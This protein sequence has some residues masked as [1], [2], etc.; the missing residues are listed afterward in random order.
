MSEICGG[1][2]TPKYKEGYFIEAMPDIFPILENNLKYCNQ[3]HGTNYKPINA[4][5]TNEDDETY[6]F[7]IFR[8]GAETHSGSS[9]IYE[10][11]EDIWDH[12]IGAHVRKTMSI[13]L[14]STK[15][16]TL[17]EKYN[18]NFDGGADMIM[19][20]QGAELDVL[21]SFGK[22]LDKFDSLL[23]EVSTKDYYSGSPLFDEIHTYLRSRGFKLWSEKIPSHGDVYFVRESTPD[24]PVESPVPLK[25]IKNYVITPDGFDIEVY[26]KSPGLLKVFVKHEK[27]WD[28]DLSFTLIGENGVVYTITVG[29]SGN[30]E[31]TVVHST[32]AKLIF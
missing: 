29:K 23:I 17:I 2:Y 24:L 11:R 9:S 26:S 31:K 3:T 22:Y 15:M 32:D 5:V 27:S 4:L 30:P 25:K 1:Y 14:K 16:S 28:S 21:K 10:E 18:M 12:D 20:V 8:N 6:R 7:N 19:D 13:E